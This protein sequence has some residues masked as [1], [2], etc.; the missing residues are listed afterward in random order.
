MNDIIIYDSEKSDG[1]A[2]QIKSQASV[3]YAS[4]M[5]GARDLTESSVLSE[6]LSSKASDFL[7]SAGR[8]DDDIYHSYTKLWIQI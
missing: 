8:D 6:A 1:I 4:Q 7:A 3:A 5:L 2:E